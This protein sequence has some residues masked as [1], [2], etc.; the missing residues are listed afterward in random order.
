MA[1]HKSM[2][3]MRFGD[4]L[5]H[6]SSGPERVRGSRQRDGA[7]GLSAIIPRTPTHGRQGGSGSSGAHGTG[8]SGGTGRRAGLRIQWGNP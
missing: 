2:I 8:E 7:H 1:C 3:F 4:N 5:S 6:V